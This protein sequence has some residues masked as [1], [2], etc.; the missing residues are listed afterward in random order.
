GLH[1]G[2]DGNGA[3]RFLDKAKYRGE[4]ELLR[5][6]EVLDALRDVPKEKNK[7]LILEPAQISAYWSRGM[8]HND[9]VRELKKLE[10][11]ISDENLVVLCASDVDQRSWPSAQR[12]LTVFAD[13]LM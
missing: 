11:R 10:K 2:V 6:E 1:G 5:I 7:V 12:G 8:L 9:F 3:Y 4:E 13:I